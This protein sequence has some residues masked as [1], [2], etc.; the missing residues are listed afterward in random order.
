LII[1]NGIFSYKFFFNSI[2]REIIRSDL[3]INPNTFVIGHSGRF[4]EQKNHIFIMD[5]FE[6]FLLLN[7]NSLLVLLGDGPLINNIRD[8]AVKKGISS[9]VIFA[10]SVKNVYDYLN[11]F[12][13]F[14]FPSIYEGLGIS[15][16]EAQFNSLF[17]FGSNISSLLEAKFSKLTEFINLNLGPHYWAS[18]IYKIYLDRNFLRLPLNDISDDYSEFDITHTVDKLLDFY[19]YHD[20]D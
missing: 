11:A 12:D 15:F 14:L 20:A 8:I 7:Q 3:N 4:A 13:I 2:A 10:G 9:K 18:E 19:G 1:K 16:I 6:E 17:C 5:V